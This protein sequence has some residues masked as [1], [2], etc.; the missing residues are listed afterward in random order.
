MIWGKCRGKKYFNLF[1][2]YLIPNG[3]IA[4]AVRMTSFLYE[5][6]MEQIDDSPV[7]FSHYVVFSVS[8]LFFISDGVLYYKTKYFILIGNFKRFV[9][10]LLV[11]P[12]LFLWIK[13]IILQHMLLECIYF[14]NTFQVF[15][16]FSNYFVSHEYSW[17]N[18]SKIRPTREC[19]FFDVYLTVN[20]LNPTLF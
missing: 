9:P 5:K 20:L 8:I 6:Q 13:T 14:I 19:A 18:E 1:S 16:F 2:E 12:I 11:H 17:C 3:Q 4:K 15:F 10:F 7:D